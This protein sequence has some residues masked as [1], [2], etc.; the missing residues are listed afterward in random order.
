[1]CVSFREWTF[2]SKEESI[3]LEF[4]VDMS[5]LGNFLDVEIGVL[6]TSIVERKLVFC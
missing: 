3:N 4:V 1:M 5:N 2:L 6:F